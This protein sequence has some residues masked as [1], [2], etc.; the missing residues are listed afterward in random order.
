[1]LIIGHRGARNEAPEN[2][3][4]GFQ[5]LRSLGIHQVE[6]D[7]RLSKDEQLVVIH[8]STLDRTSNG[9]GLVRHHT[10]SELQMLD[11]S[12]GFEL[13]QPTPVPTLRQVLD[14][15]PQ[16]DYI[17]LEIKSAEV[18]CLEILC[19]Q[20]TRLV[21]EYQMMDRAV[22]TSSDTKVLALMLANDARIHRGLVAE[23]FTRN[24]IQ[25]CHR[26]GCS[27]LVVNHQR[28]SP[29]LIQTAQQQGLIVSV[30]TV[31][32]L[33]KAEKLMRW[34]ADSIITDEPTK[35]ATHFYGSN[36]A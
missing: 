20:I 31:N 28:C 27:H 12:A 23:R 25:T 24:P 26:Y 2:T 17:Q 11:A 4:A 7:V 19:R 21:M 18:A 10:S 6:L 36:F 1:M 5:H 14:E 29:R 9:K 30:W 34:G 22:V 13:N 35:M 32:T 33:N 16:L 3:L 15:W 8:D